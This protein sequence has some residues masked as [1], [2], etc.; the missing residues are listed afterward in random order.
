MLHKIYFVSTYVSVCMFMCEDKNFGN[1]SCVKFY[2]GKG[3]HVNHN[4][5]AFKIIVTNNYYEI[6]IKCVGSFETFFMGMI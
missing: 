3:F 2:K 5:Y 1:Y 4:I 6:S